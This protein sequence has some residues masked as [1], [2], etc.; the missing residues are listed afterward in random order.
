MLLRRSHRKAAI[1]LDAAIS[2]IGLSGRHFGVM[3]LLDRDG[4]SIQRDLIAQTGSDK[5][6]MARTIRELDARGYVNLRPSSTDRRVVH[7]SLND[8]GRDAF[9]EAR[10]RAGGV[11]AQM[12]A[13]FDDD[14]VTQLTSLLS[15]FLSG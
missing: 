11:A 14:D 6:G 8:Y 12:F 13:A 5:A 15:R 2:P 9:A 3:L 1:A 4:T 10:A 7:I